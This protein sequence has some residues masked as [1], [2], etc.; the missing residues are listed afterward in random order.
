MSSSP[1]TVDLPV[2]V[3]IV[4]AQN[5]WPG[6]APYTEEL[7]NFFCGR[8]EETEELFRRVK[9]RPL[10][11]LFGQ[12]G[13]GKTSLIQ[14]GLFPRLHREGFLPVP[15]RLLFTSDEPGKPPPEPM[16]QVKLALG[17][18]MREAGLKDC[19]WPNKAEPL[20]EYFHR[21]DVEL[22]G[23]DDKPLCP[24]LVFDQFE[25]FFTRGQESEAA[26][27]QSAAFLTELA[28]LVE[29]YTPAAL[30]RRLLAQPGLLKRFNFDKQDYRV[31]LSLREDYLPHLEGLRERLPSLTQNRFRLTPLRYWQ[32]L[33]AVQVPGAG[34]VAPEVARQI[35]RF[36]ATGKHTVGND[37]GQTSEDV[38]HL[39]V[40]P[41]LLNLVCH[42]LNIR[43]QVRG[44]D[45]VTPDL[46]AASSTEILRDFYQHCLADQ[47]PG[48]QA[49]IEEEL[50]TPSGLRENISLERARQALAER[51]APTEAIEEL[52]RRRLLHVEER[53]QAQ[54]VELT[55]DVLT[56]VVRKS[57]DERQQ[58][59]AVQKARSKLRQSR[60][61]LVVVAILAGVFAL[62]AAIGIIGWSRAYFALEQAQEALVTAN[63]EKRHAEEEKK[64]A[65]DALKEAEKQKQHAEQEKQRADDNLKKAERALAEAKRQEQRAE[66]AER[67]VMSSKQELERLIKQAKQT[68]EPK[69]KTPLIGKTKDLKLPSAGE[70]REEGAIIKEGQ[71]DY[72]RLVP[73]KGGPLVAE[74]SLPET[75]SLDTVLYLLDEQKQRITD[76]TNFSVRQPRIL[77]F[78]VQAGATYY[79]KVVAYQR[80][81]ASERTGAY[82]LTIR[83]GQVSSVPVVGPSKDGG[84]VILS[85]QS[86]LTKDDPFDK[87]REQCHA[88][89]F[90]INLT[91]GKTYQIDMRSE[92]IDPYLR[93]EDPD[94][95]EVAHDDDGGGDLNAR[96]VYSCPQSGAYRVIATTFTSKSFRG[97]QPT[98]PFTLTVRI[99]GK[100]GGEPSKPATAPGFEKALELKLKADGTA[101]T[102]GLIKT[103]GQVDLF[104]FKASQTGRAIV[105][106]TRNKGSNLDCSLVAYDADGKELIRDD[107]PDESFVSFR[108]Q[109]GQ[110]YYVRAAAGADFVDPS[111]QTGAYTLTLRMGPD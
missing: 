65:D 40:E 91:A 99:L 71:E 51:Q 28:D 73:D 5:P 60:R 15:I 66:A 17:T 52:V 38:S 87:V 62:L 39:E 7:H 8:D 9:R 56:A 12:S 96:I 82:V 55:H 18:A 44:L 89:T 77:P 33:D 13:L 102:S 24:V 35:V 2:L 11:V 3:P 36:V 103:I 47:S 10:T 19:S 6:L 20:W 101:E 105:K 45:R 54:R 57:R 1:A 95:T 41:S 25:E 80:A 26:R 104:R 100:A 83:P 61:R 92:V 49:F 30:E 21:R 59:E 76:V 42:E 50:L 72:F 27:L 108:V 70:V 68:E 110:V 90:T 111:R 14:A 43:R 75:S 79:L 23:L 94:G 109:A 84:Q 16:T 81:I 88:K 48:V 53:L 29:N 78:T 85:E 22:K 46:L 98:G 34:L 69:K 97:R 67:Q 93:L 37:D 63:G 31:L 32:A 106:M 107:V 58:K 86:K 64:R 4:D 74:L